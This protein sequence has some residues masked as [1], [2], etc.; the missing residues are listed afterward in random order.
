MQPRSA[1]II[2]LRVRRDA[3]R[4]RRDM[5][6]CCV[7]IVA[8]A[9]RSRRSTTRT[10]RTCCVRPQGAITAGV[11]RALSSHSDRRGRVL[12]QEQAHNERLH[13]GHQQALRPRHFQSGRSVGRRAVAVGSTLMDPVVRTEV[14]TLRDIAAHAKA[15]CFPQNKHFHGMLG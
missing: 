10:C 12:P 6:T 4:R 5:T 1:T 11:Q 15:K 14:I 13:E 9:Q 3:D 7:S 2:A 8:A